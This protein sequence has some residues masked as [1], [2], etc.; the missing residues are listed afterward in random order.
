MRAYG[1]DDPV[2]FHGK[3]DTH[4]RHGGANW[5]EIDMT[6]KSRERMK[7]KKDIQQQLEEDE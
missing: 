5:W 6:S 1:R 2:K 3:L 4:P 7:A